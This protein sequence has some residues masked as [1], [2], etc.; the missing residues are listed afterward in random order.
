MNFKPRPDALPAPQRALWPEL[1]QVP[2]HF[3]LYGT[4]LALRLGHRQSVDF[5]FFSSEPVN[6]ERLLDTLP[7]LRGCQVRQAGEN[8]LTALLNREGG[9]V[10]VTFI[11]A[12][13]WRRVNEPLKC[14]DSY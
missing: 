9:G 13:P 4:A 12:L 7:L 3:V 1:K 2:D 6:P 11:G 5:D 14:A 10:F 8:T